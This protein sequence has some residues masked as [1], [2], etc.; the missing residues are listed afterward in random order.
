MK[1]I[2]TREWLLKE[3]KR[4][5]EGEFVVTKYN[6]PLFVV[7]ISLYKG[8]KV[9]TNPLKGLKNVVTIDNVTTKLSEIAAKK[10][11]VTT[12]TTPNVTTNDY[13]SDYDAKLIAEQQAI[14]KQRDYNRTH[15]SCGCLK[16]DDYVCSKHSRA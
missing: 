14:N 1:T 4:L 6:K 5:Q 3:S 8:E 12:K 9:V 13:I 10:E 16:A 7:T 11:N 15:Y 2:S